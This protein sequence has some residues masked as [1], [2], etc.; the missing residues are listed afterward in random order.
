RV[1]RR[2]VAELPEVHLRRLV[3][4][5]LAPHDAV[6]GELGGGGAAAEDVPDAVVFVRLQPE[7]GPGLL[8]L[9]RLLGDLHRVD[10]H[11][12]TPTSLRSSLACARCDAHSGV[13]FV[14]HAATTAFSTD[15][16]KPRPSVDGPVRS[17]TACSG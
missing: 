4:A 8:V 2:Q 7:L 10:L 15:V 1:T 17:S 3:G 16:K 11:Y 9:R 6:H 12:S 14:G 13:V 5:V